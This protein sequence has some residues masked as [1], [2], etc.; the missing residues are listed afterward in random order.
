MKIAYSFGMVDFF[1]YGHAKALLAAKKACDRHIFGLVS[2]KTSKAWFG[3]MLSNY[4]ERKSVLEQITCIDEI[5]YQETFDPTDNL[6]IIHDKYPDAEIILYHGNDWKIMPA[7]DYIKSINGKVVLTEY[8]KKLSPANI[9]KKLNSHEENERPRNNLI[10]TKAN[11]L[12]AL[13]PLLE[14]SSIEDIQIITIHDYLKDPDRVIEHLQQSF[15]GR[16]IVVRSSSSGE[17]C[18][19]TSNAGHFESILGVDSASRQAIIDAVEAVIHSYGYKE[20]E[21]D[22]AAGEQVLIQSQTCDVVKSGVIFTRDINENRPYYVIN[23]DDHGSTNLVTSGM[24]GSVVWIMRNIKAE[25]VSGQWRGLLEA[26]WEIEKILTEMVLDIEFAIKANGEI[27]IFQVRPLAANYRFHKRFDDNAFFEQ[28]N[29]GKVAYKR[30]DGAIGYETVQL[31]DMAF[32]NPAEIIGA[33]PH[34]LDYSLYREIITKR[35]W[36]E[37]IA[38]MGYRKLPKDLMYRIGNKPYIRLD[39][40]FYSLIPQ[41][42]SEQTSKKLVKYYSRKLETDVSMHDKIEF[43]IVISCYDYSIREQL[44]GLDSEEFTKEE[45]E[46]I[47]E[48]LRNLTESGISEYETVLHRDLG[49][50]GE[51]T[52]TSESISDKIAFQ[53]NNIFALIKYFKELIAGIKRSGTPAF[54]RQAR[55]AFIAARLCQTMV[56]SSY[57]TSEE[58]TAFKNS[59]HTVA[60]DFEQDFKMYMQN[61]MSK[62][63]FNEKYGHL[64]SGTYDIRSPRYDQIDFASN[65]KDENNRHLSYEKSGKGRKLDQEKLEKALKD[66]GFRVTLEEYESFLKKSLEMRE[67]FKFEFTKALSLAIEILALIGKNLDIGRKELSHLEMADILAS[68]YYDTA[69]ELKMFWQTI[70]E[71]RRQE[72]K[73]NSQLILPEV[74][75]RE[76]DMCEVHICTARPN[77]ITLGKAEGAVAVLDQEENADIRGKI[78]VIEKADPGYDWIFTQEIAGL[79]TKYGG[80]ASHMAIRCAEFDLPAAIGCG[81]KIYQYVTGCARICLDCKKGEITQI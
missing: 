38:Q 49:L 37:G 18:Y 20:D 26:V 1:H 80:V 8:Y 58:M 35:A 52:K 40:A 22:K 47:A 29:K 5:M 17:D 4:E 30:L 44:N 79:I 24:G 56:E 45:K 69:D 28:L 70:I 42:V 34:N 71:Q 23:Y 77:F 60:S 11:T 57:F 25:D 62:K 51:L 73:R 55:Y 65:Q 59:V 78:V 32:W 7:M 15:R 48:C 13:K 6:K 74:V 41:A 16:K 39:Y 76:N 66:I 67:Y 10:S 46:E 19:E 64:R 81:E 50:L 75:L 3:T 53:E 27:V 63:Q 31:S 43:E 14:K 68:E 54:S 33:N 61:K 72:Y 21:Y 9:L 2:D 36:N 12:L